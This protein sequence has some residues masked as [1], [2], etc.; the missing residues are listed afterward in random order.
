MSSVEVF[1]GKK[2]NYCET[3]IPNPLNVYGNM[4]KEIEDYLINQSGDYCIVRTGWN[5]GWNLNHRCVVTLTY[6]TL[7]KDNAF[8]ATDNN[9]S[10]TD[11]EDTSKCL[12]ELVEHKEVKCC[13]IAS[14]KSLLRVELA[15]LVICHSKNKRKMSYQRTTFDKIP[16][17]EKR[18]RLNNINNSFLKSLFDYSFKNPTDI[19][20]RKVE[21]LD[22]NF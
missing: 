17:T 2:G 6:E 13:H 9:F 7:I 22:K 4:K 10:I 8:M 15:D 3:D 19:V 14:D 21:I 12:T 18:S 5:V 20:R 16:Y 11:V 1:D